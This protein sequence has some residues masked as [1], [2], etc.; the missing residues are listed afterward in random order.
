MCPIFRIVAF[1]L[2][3]FAIAPAQADGRFITLS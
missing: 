1:V 3:I 2:A